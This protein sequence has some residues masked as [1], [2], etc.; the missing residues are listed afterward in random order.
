MQ[1][2]LFLYYL[3]NASWWLVI[4]VGPTSP[5]ATPDLWCR[6][7]TS[8][9]EPLQACERRGAVGSKIVAHIAREG[10]VAAP[11]FLPAVA[12]GWGGVEQGSCRGKDQSMARSLSFS[13][14]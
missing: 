2:Y 7:A 12:H 6:P 14:E 4:V 11:G 1:T 13:R 5:S 10:E 8:R 9:S 3:K